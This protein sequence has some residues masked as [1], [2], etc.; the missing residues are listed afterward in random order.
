MPL[1][2]SISEATRRRNNPLVLRLMC[3]PMDVAKVQ[4]DTRKKM[5]HKQNRT[6][7]S[8]PKSQPW[9]NLVKPFFTV[10]KGSRP[11]SACPASATFRSNGSLCSREPLKRKDRVHVIQSSMHGISSGLQTKM[12]D[13]GTVVTMCWSSPLPMSEVRSL[14]GAIGNKPRQVS[15][16]LKTQIMIHI[17]MVELLKIYVESWAS[18]WW[19]SGLH[20]LGIHFHGL[21]Q[22]Y[23]Q[24]AHG[25][26]GNG[27]I[28]EGIQHKIHWMY[29]A[30]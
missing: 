28:L 5:N 25:S 20:F 18:C 15:S 16:K 14:V 13:R 6:A 22:E 29:C 10:R 27:R 3:W 30:Q 26:A 8:W 9:N 21:L 19:A 23:L 4:K 7:K 24:F 11:F 1:I 17:L 2:G 12:D